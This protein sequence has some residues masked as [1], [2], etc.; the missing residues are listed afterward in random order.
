[1]KKPRKVQPLLEELRKIP[2]VSLACERVGISRNTFYRWMQEDAAFK[3]EID[4]AHELGIDSINDLAESKLVQHINNGN[5]Q[6]IKYW[7]GNNKKNYR[8]PRPPEPL[9]APRGD[10]IF[11]FEPIEEHWGKKKKQL[12]TEKKD[13]DTKDSQTGEV[14][15]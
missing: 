12:E 14:L 1:M 13:F 4:E 6:A 10:I 11:N 3:K 7:L 8:V 9:V 15:E 5:M 2:N